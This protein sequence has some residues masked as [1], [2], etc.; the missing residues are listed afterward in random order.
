M[1]GCNICNS[2]NYKVLYKDKYI[3]SICKDCGHVFQSSRKESSHYHELPY[4]SQW[5]NYMKHSEDRAK[6]I[7]QFIPVEF[8]DKIKKVTDI[9][10]GPGGVLYH[11]NKQFPT[12]EMYGVT[13]HNDKERVL[14]GIKVFYGDFEVNNFIEKCDLV[15]MCHVMEHFIDPLQALSKIHEM[16]NDDGLVYIEV[17]SFHWAEIRSK[18]QFCPVH[19]S[20]FSKQKLT[21]ILNKEGFDII[22]IHESK[23]WG[24]IKILAKKTTK[25]ET[26]LKENYLNKILELYFNRLINFKIY[27]FIKMFKKLK[28]ND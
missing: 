5:D 13:T 14:E 17:P 11:I 21:Q 25:L 4:E 20:Y 7:I 10:C 27:K 9:G 6:Y 1:D 16:L 8:L 3:Y 23:Y 15:V 18:P 2:L 26:S 19:L 12:W 22:K 28:A 24:N